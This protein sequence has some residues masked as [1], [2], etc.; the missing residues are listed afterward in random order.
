[1]IIAYCERCAGVWHVQK[2]RNP[3]LMEGSCMDCQNDSDSEKPL[4]FGILFDGVDTLDDLPDS[5]LA[6]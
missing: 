1:M 2:D 3:M 5:W 4:V 6:E